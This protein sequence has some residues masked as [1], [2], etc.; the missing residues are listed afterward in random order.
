M[1]Y[2]KGETG[3]PNGRP[4]GAENI[5]TKVGKELL[6]EVIEG[7]MQ[8]VQAALEKLL[9]ED[10]KAYLDVL[11]KYM[12]FVIPEKTDLSNNGKSFDNNNETI[13]TFRNFSKN[14]EDEKE[15]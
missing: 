15:N 11:T 5:T 10:T 8:N 6:I 2:K 4:K 1:K 14:A 9:K 7:Q 12:K 13:V 3:N